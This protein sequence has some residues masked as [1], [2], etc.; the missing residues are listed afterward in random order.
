M[1]EEIKSK[2]DFGV[3]CVLWQRQAD[4]PDNLPEEHY[5]LMLPLS[6]VR[7]KDGCR[8]FPY[9]LRD[10]EKIYLMDF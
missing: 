10:D 3:I 2:Y 5:S 1:T 6:R 8:I 7:R 9:I 4:L